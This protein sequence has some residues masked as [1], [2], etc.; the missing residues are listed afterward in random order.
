[1]IN[2][3][4]FFNNIANVPKAAPEERDPTSPI[5]IKAGFALNHKNPRQ[6]PKK[7]AA[8]IVNSLAKGM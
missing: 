1:M 3:T 8:K 2:K 5:K 4:S 6:P 7:A